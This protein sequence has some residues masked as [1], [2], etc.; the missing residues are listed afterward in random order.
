MMMEKD[1]SFLG[2]DYNV[3]VEDAKPTKPQNIKSWF[4]SIQAIEY[5]LIMVCFGP[6]MTMI[7]DSIENSNQILSC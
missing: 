6:I 7:F 4:F 3:S 2:H 1:I 5:V